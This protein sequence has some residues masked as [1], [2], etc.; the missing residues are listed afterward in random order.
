VG[1]LSLSAMAINNKIIRLRRHN[2]NKK[3]YRNLLRR[4]RD[5][6]KEES[7][8]LKWE[9]K[10]LKSFLKFKGYTEEQIIR[11]SLLRGKK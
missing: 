7:S 9:N 5:R 4:Q 6:L 2:M 10:N 3:E 1:K 8:L 11:V